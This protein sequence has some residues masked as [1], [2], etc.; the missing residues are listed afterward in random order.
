MIGVEPVTKGT[1]FLL[2][3]HD[4]LR[5]DDSSIDLE[6]VANDARIVEQTL[7]IFFPVQCYFGNIKAII[8]VAKVFRFSQNSDPRKTCLVDLQNETFE[9]RIIVLQWK[10]I[11]C[12]VIGFVEN[13]FRMR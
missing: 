12:I 6:P 5:I 7:Y 3:L 9:E 4:L 2:Q 13:I 8:R 11:L 1:I 10:S